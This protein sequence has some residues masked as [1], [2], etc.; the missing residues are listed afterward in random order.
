MFPPPYLVTAKSGR[1]KITFA[2]C[3]RIGIVLV[4][5]IVKVSQHPLRTNALIALLTLK[6]SSTAAG[7]TIIVEDGIVAPPN[8]IAKEIA[9]TV[10]PV[11]IA[12]L[13][14]KSTW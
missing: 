7:V 9:P 12:I 6:Y 10:S 14:P 11:G 4:F 13:A 1:L 3:T 2:F 5:L 8:V